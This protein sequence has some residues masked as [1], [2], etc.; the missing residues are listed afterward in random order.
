MFIYLE[1]Y[2]GSNSVGDLVDDLSI[3]ATAVVHVS[4]HDRKKLQRKSSD[5]TSN[6]DI[7]KTNIS[8]TQ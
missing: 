6:S 5:F 2:F 1:S 3:K 8:Q 4:H 7:K